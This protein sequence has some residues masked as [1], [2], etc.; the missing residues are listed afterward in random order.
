MYRNT[1]LKSYI[2]KNS[3]DCHS[4]EDTTLHVNIYYIYQTFVRSS[5]LSKRVADHV[6]CFR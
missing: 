5:Q 3:F 2:K 6:S 4:F 1:F